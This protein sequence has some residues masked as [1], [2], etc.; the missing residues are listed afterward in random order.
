MVCLFQAIGL[1]LLQRYSKSNSENQQTQIQTKAPQFFCERPTS[2]GIAISSYCNLSISRFPFSVILDLCLPWQVGLPLPTGNVA[3][4]T[5][6]WLEEWVKK[7]K[8]LV[9][10]QRQQVL[11]QRARSREEKQQRMEGQQRH[12]MG[13]SGENETE[14]EAS[15][16]ERVRGSTAASVGQT[17]GAVILDVGSSRGGT[18]TPGSRVSGRARTLVLTS[19]QVRNAEGARERMLIGATRGR[20]GLGRGCATTTSTGKSAKRKRSQVAIARSRGK[21][22]KRGRGRR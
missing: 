20:G 22:G 7:H 11:Q 5:S 9:E 4:G 18:G 10:E 6:D 12:N 16:A 13:G 17:Q 19:E 21:G 3:K 1:Q 8:E 2:S 14:Q 15:R